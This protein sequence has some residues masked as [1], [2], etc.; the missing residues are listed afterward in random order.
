MRPRTTFDEI[1]DAV[2]HLPADEQAE[3]DDVI[4]RRLSEN[5]RKQIVADA[6]EARLEHASGKT[7]L[8]TVDELMC[9]FEP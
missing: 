5:G 2:E 8:V 1:L 4:R 9:E 6:Q 3:L 7:R